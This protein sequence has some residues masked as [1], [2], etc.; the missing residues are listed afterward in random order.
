MAP[1]ESEDDVVMQSDA[2]DAA[3]GVEGEEEEEEFEVENIIKAK[4]ADDVSISPFSQLNIALFIRKC[5]V[6]GHI[7]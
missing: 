3:A 4:R 2:E 6:F 5:R 7:T 1:A